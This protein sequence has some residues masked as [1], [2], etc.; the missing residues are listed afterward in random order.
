MKT[1]VKEE[2][3]APIVKEESGK[4]NNPSEK[5]PS[6]EKEEPVKVEVRV[7]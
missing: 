7:L 2:S 3:L 1:E 4:E 5:E 6:I